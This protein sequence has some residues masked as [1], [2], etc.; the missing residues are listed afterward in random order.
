M[1]GNK[2]RKKGGV[3]QQQKVDTIQRKLDALELK[4][5]G[6]NYRVIAETLGYRGPS[7]AWKAV[8]CALRDVLREPAEEVLKL[9][10][11][12][13]DSLF[14]AYYPDAKKGIRDAGYIC[15]KIIG[16]RCKLLGL[17]A[18]QQIEL[19]GT[20]GGPVLIREVRIHVDD[21]D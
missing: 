14:L 7:G 10:L 1:A 21:D 19:T 2:K 11:L 13:L 6:A 9:E 12:R 15:L 3:R 16:Q 5:A 4:K 18:P 20:D 8:H 17:D